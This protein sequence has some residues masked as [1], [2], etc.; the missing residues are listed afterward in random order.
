MT[1]ILNALSRRSSRL[2]PRHSLR[3]QAAGLENKCA[4][5]ISQ[6]ITTTPRLMMMRCVNLT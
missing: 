4:K 5:R 2:R 3:N 1:R 6:I